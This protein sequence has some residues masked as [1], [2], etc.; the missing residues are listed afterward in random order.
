MLE[1]IAE[2]EGMTVSDVVRQYARRTH[3]ALFGD[4]QSARK[5]GK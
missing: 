2:A 3:A 1:R 5:G 4:K